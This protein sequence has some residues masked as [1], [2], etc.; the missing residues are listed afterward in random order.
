MPSSS[1]SFNRRQQVDALGYRSRGNS[2]HCDPVHKIQRIPSSA[3]RSFAQGRPPRG[4]S[5]RRGR[6]GSILSHCSSVNPR[7]IAP[8][9]LGA[10][11]SGEILKSTS[12]Y[13][14]ASRV[15]CSTL[16]RSLS[17]PSPCPLPLRGRGILRG[18]SIF[19]SLPHWGRGPQFELKGEALRRGLSKSGGMAPRS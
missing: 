19:P 15:H 9:S 1:H 17:A 16:C 5:L 3:L 12:G 11:P 14:M 2:L 4:F 8:L 6:C 7:H 18:S 10:N 13:E